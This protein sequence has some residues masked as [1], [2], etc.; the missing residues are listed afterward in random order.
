MPVPVRL[1]PILPTVPLLLAALVIPGCASFRAANQP[2]GR[3]QPDHGY[4][5]SRIQKERPAGRVLLFLA[6]SG[7]GTRAAALS[8]GV[9][10]ELRD[11]EVTVGG[12]R[13]RLLDEVDVITSVSGGSFTAAYY[14]LHGDGIFEDFEDRFLRKNI[15][16]SLLLELLKPQSWLR[17]ASRFLDRSELA[18]HLY[19]Q[20]IFD[21]AT[22]ADLLAARGPLLQINATDMAAGRHFTFYQEQFDFLCSDLSSF[23]VARA[24]AASSA[25]PVLFSPIVLKNYAGCGFE[26][27]AWLD[28]ALRERRTNP[29]RF[30]IAQIMDGYLDTRDRPYVHLLDGGIADNIGLRVPLDN[31]AL[32]GGPFARMQEVGIEPFDHVAVIVVNAEVR[33]KAEFGLAAASPGLGAILGSVSNI[34]IYGRNADTI[35]LMR[36]SLRQWARE[37][38]PHRGG[39]PPGTSLVTLGFEDIED[40]DERRFFQSVPTS[41]SL[42]D[43]T[44]DRLIAV[45]RR[46]LRES[47]DYRAFLAELAA[48]ARRP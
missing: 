10:Q 17:L 33:P 31:V 4:R 26:R 1:R 20:R 11:T 30:R 12:K 44:V 40:P 8:Y 42:P 28:E 22:F 34:Q 32:T 13:E 23:P 7:G 37:L 3:W 14:G 25:V 46:L 9:L 18:I 19:D 35:E 5:A 6:F 38:A 48:D 36:E 45:A 41:F 27:P 21:H 43:T 16:G 2:L 29:R 39:R 47:P 24:V 15:Q